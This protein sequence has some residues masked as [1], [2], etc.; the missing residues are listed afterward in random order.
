MKVKYPAIDLLIFL[1]R[2]FGYLQLI[3]AGATFFGLDAMPS[4]F[5]MVS[6]VF[7]L[8]SSFLT[9]AVGEILRLFVDICDYSRRTVF[10][11]EELNRNSTK[12]G[13]MTV[14]N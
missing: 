7:L 3:L 12:D 13:D 1:L 2:L 8:V 4:S 14:G 10:L 9:F 6:A 5:G 11:L